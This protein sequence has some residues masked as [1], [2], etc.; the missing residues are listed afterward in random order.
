MKISGKIV[1]SLITLSALVVVTGLCGHHFIH[2]LGQEGHVTANEVAPHIH[3]IKSIRTHVEKAHWR[4]EAMASDWQGQPFDPVDDEFRMAQ[5]FCRLALEGGEYKGWVYGP[6]K[7]DDRREVISTLLEEIVVLRQ[8]AWERHR[9]LRR[10]QTVGSD[11]DVRFDESYEKL[12]AEA[13]GFSGMG[14]DPEETSRMVG[15]IRYLLANGHLLVAEILGGDG[16]EDPDEAISNFKSARNLAVGLA[17]ASGRDTSSLVQGIEVLIED[18]QNRFR[19]TGENNRNLHQAW[20][21]FVDAYAKFE[22]NAKAL[23]G[24]MRGELGGFTTRLEK[25]A[26]HAEQAFFTLVVMSLFITAGIG[27]HLY[28]NVIRPTRNIAGLL[29]RAARENL[30]MIRLPYERQDELG[31]I[32]RSFNHFM[33]AREETQRELASARRYIDGIT[34]NVP[35]LLAYVDSDKH[36]RFVNR[37]FQEWFGGCPEEAIG[38]RI[39]EVFDGSVHVGMEAHVDDALAGRRE[40]F[41]LELSSEGLAERNISICLLPDHGRDEGVDGLFVSMDDITAAKVLERTLRQA[42]MDAEQTARSKSDFLANMSHEIRT[43]MNG[44]I[45]MTKLL[46]DSGLRADQKSQA[47]TILRSAESLLGLINDILDFS[48]VEAGKLELEPVRFELGAMLEDLGTSM[49]FKAEERNVDLVCPAEVV[50]HCWVMADPG[51]I[52]QILT[53]LIGNAIKFT[54]NGEVVAHCRRLGGG[55]DVVKLRFEV[56]DDGIGLKPE[57][58]E[59]LFERFTQ[60]DASTTRKYGGTGLGLA[61]CRQLTEL[62]GGEIG[63][64]SEYGKGST[65]WFTLDLPLVAPPMEP[66]RCRELRDQKVLVVEPA[67]LHRGRFGEM[68]SNWGVDHSLAPDVDSALIQ[69]R[70]AARAGS[71]FTVLLVERRLRE[72]DALRLGGDLKREAERQGMKLLMICQSVDSKVNDEAMNEGFEGVLRKPV[73]QS[74]LYDSLMRISTSGGPDAFEGEQAKRKFPVFS[75]RIL[76]A[77]DNSV[78]QIVARGLIGKLGL[79]VDVVGNGL[80]VLS[81]LS[82]LP[83]DLVFMDCQMPELDGFETSRRIRSRQTHILD[84]E[85]PIVAMTANAM[86]G[87]REA[88]LE[89]GMND[90]LAKPI[91]LKGLIEVLRRWVPELEVLEDGEDLETSEASGQPDSMKE[92]S[93]LPVLDAEELLDRLDGDREIVHEILREFIDDI[94]PKVRMLSVEVSTGNWGEVRELAHAIKGASANVAAERLQDLASRFENLALDASLDEMKRLVPRLAEEWKILAEAIERELGTPVST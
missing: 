42:T 77:E 72:P 85:I 39:D 61:I 55:E 11:S 1:V 81:S 58:Q 43:P 69:M 53:N 45:G 76:V 40:D 2:R 41:E 7:R 35:Q 64:T 84:H 4:I 17:R 49:A 46:L 50:E 56:V 83:Y 29:D 14:P 37:T 34:D 62:M 21:S 88:C 90:H 54:E 16:G 33:S 8:S 3:A 57:Q 20:A 18:A 10:T 47:C 70:E 52:R 82:Q 31:Q 44:V 25:N 91:A 48:K 23:D 92:E 87:D 38:R 22:S 79:V 15:E 24:V 59:K 74:T 19:I 73:S 75:G 28:G 66:L 86:K 65:F 89:S 27:G 68:L 30:A 71:P 9:A 51:R 32:A 26:R 13:P 5:E 67:N 78:N 63:V 80:E 6:M 12:I 93:D 36:F 60:A 94:P